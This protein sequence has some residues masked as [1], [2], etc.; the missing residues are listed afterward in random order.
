MTKGLGG[1]GLGAGLNLQTQNPIEADINRS[2]DISHCIV[3]WQD[4]VD[5]NRP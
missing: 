5:P 1:T 3:G 2:G 4:C